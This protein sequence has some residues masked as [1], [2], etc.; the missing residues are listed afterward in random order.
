MKRIIT[1][2]AALLLTAGVFAQSPQKMSYQAVIRNITNQLIINHAVGM[3]INILQGS[4]SGTAVYVETQ[5]TTTNGNGLAS[6]EIGSGTVVN[7]NF[8]SIDW[9]N[10]PYFIK[11]ESD[12]AGG[13]NYSITET[14]Q[15]LSVPYALH[16]KTAEKIATDISY[17]HYIGEQYGGGVIFDLWKDI[18]GVEHGLIVA[19]TDQ[20]TSHYWSNNDSVAQ[21]GQSFTDGMSNSNTIGLTGDTSGVVLMCLN[22]VSG[23]Q[24]DWYLPAI[25]EM[26]PLFNNRFEVNKAL[27]NISGAT[28]LNYSGSYWSSTEDSSIPGSPGVS[29]FKYDF[30]GQSMGLISS[31]MK[32]LGL[33]SVRAIRT[34]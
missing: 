21:G 5:T 3:K 33:Y 7:G 16:A 9:A 11:T 24:S 19:I 12:P 8:S 31:D 34:F 6:I 1:I 2:F 18:A 26:I 10:G 13:T 14:S 29:A 4:A 15:F 27:S 17:T 23:G 28:P 22:L 30:H 25:D 32:T 20:S